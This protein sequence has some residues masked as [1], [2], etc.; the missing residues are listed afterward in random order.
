QLLSDG[1]SLGIIGIDNKEYPM[2]ALPDIMKRLEDRK[3]L[4]E[5]KMKEGF[6]KII[7]VPFACP[8]EVIIKKYEEALVR[9]SDGYGL[10]ATKSAAGDRD[11]KLALD[12]A[13]P[14]N[15]WNEY[16]DGDVKNNFIY[17]PQ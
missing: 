3:E 13:N 9:H 14:I 1:K 12:P 2:P 10:L 17:F 11:E 5:R 15:I 16:K 7:L 6:T 4:A 8:L